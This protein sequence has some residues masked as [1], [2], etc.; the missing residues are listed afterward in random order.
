VNSC[1]PTLRTIRSR[2]GHWSPRSPPGYVRP[3][4]VSRLELEII[5]TRRNGLL[6]SDTGVRTSGLFRVRA[7]LSAH[8]SL[9]PP[10]VSACESAGDQAGSPRLA[11][12]L[13]VRARRAWR[14]SAGR[15][16]GGGP[17]LV[18][19]APSRWCTRASVYVSRR[20]GAPLV[21]SLFRLMMDP[22]PW[23][24]DCNSAP[25]SGGRTGAK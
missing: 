22:R 15:S 6:V 14:G 12:S 4:H 10:V 21:R 19:W 1:Y 3:G 16:G 8:P 5:A 9:S 24:Q 2:L 25:A 17:P 11:G 13:A 18:G 20:R 7:A 23:G